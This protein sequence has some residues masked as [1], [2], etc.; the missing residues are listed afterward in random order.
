MYLLY[1]LCIFKF[2]AVVFFFLFCIKC[3]YCTFIINVTF[4]N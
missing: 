3:V 1:K 2:V 4:I